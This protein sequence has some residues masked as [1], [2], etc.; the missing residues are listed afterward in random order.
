MNTGASPTLTATATDFQGS[1]PTVDQSQSSDALE[2]LLELR[3][4]LGSDE[5]VNT[6]LWRVLEANRQGKLYMLQLPLGIP[7]DKVNTSPRKGPGFKRDSSTLRLLSFLCRH[8]DGGTAELKATLVAILDCAKNK[9]AGNPEE[10]E[11]RQKILT[12]LTK[13]ED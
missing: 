11:R 13:M 10:N 12:Y 3:A 2:T 6:L 5:A 8:L 9:E 4:Q 1:I 7:L